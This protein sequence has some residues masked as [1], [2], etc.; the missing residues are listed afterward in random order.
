MR[1]VSRAKEILKSIESG[2]AI[3]D[4]RWCKVRKYRCFGR[5]TGFFAGAGKTARRG[6]PREKIRSADIN[7]MTP[8]EAMNLV[9]TLKKLLES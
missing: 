3:S 6:R 9:F 4:D 5:Y 7:T 1:V 2:S 8:I